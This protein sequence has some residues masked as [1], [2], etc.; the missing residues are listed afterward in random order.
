MK[1]ITCMSVLLFI[2][3]AFILVFGVDA[4]GSTANG[5]DE[6]L[7]IARDHTANAIIVVD[8]DGT[9]VQLHAADELAHF[10]KEISGAEFPI[11]HQYP[12]TDRVK[13]LIGET[14]VR[15]AYPSCATA[16]LGED[17]IIIRSKDDNLI[18]AGNETRGTIYSVYTFLEDVLGCRWWTDTASTI[19]SMAT[20]QLPKNLNISYTPAFE[21][22]D[23]GIKDSFR[24]NPDWAVR[25]KQN[26]N[27][28]LIYAKRGYRKP[29]YGGYHS[30]YLFIPPGKYF[31]Q[32]PEW[33]SEIEG[34]RVTTARGWGGHMLPA[35]LCFTNK[36]MLEEFIKNIK[37]GPNSDGGTDTRPDYENIWVA[38]N[39]TSS[40][41]TC[42]E[43]AAL[44]A[45]EGTPAGSYLHFVNAI[46]D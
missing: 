27:N 46:A 28:C 1:K 42:K 7:I 21:Y 23:I 10:L 26:G 32:H 3:L 40:Y 22:R 16:D 33:F 39:D 43:C 37:K 18:L 44:D 15:L 4:V 31:E 29:A 19:P 9:E 17:G 41:C 8:A 6:G 12:Q 2:A 11:V 35:Q 14:A 30:V 34:K 25:N 24:T 5:N 20:I 38:P 13:I 45:H 36:E